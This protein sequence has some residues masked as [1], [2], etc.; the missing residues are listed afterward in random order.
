MTILQLITALGS[1]GGNLPL[2]LAFIETVATAWKVLQ[3]G[4]AKTAP[5][6]AAVHKL[7]AVALTSEEMAA[8]HSLHDTHMKA[9]PGQPVA[10]FDGHRIIALLSFLKSNPELLSTISQFLPIIMALFA[11][12]KPT[13]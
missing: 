3:D 6:A 4:L 2:V 12:P 1:L 11:P 13:A 7:T 5:P 9:L 8:C 10:A